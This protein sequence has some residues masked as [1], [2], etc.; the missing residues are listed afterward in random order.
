MVGYGEC[1]TSLITHFLLAMQASMVWQGGK[2][3]DIVLVCKVGF[4]IDFML[5]DKEDVFW[6]DVLYCGEWCPLAASDGNVF[7]LFKMVMQDA[8][9]NGDREKLLYVPC[10]VPD[11]TSRC[12][13]LATIDADPQSENYSKVCHLN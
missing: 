4:C 1:V 8:M 5:Y 13:Y 12:D 3:C 2:C 10:I 11:Q 7:E 6:G 9:K